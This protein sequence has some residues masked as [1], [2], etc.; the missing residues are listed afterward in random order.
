MK[1]AEMKAMSS[2]F[3]TKRI[4]NA[5]KLC[6]SGIK[7]CVKN[8]QISWNL[9]HWMLRLAFDSSFAQCELTDILAI[10]SIGQ[11]LVIKPL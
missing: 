1:K 5:S 10:S 3:G 8:A 4:T 6:Q 9:K 11:K 2:C 7:V